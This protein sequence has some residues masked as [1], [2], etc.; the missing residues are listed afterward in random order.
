[1]GHLPDNQIV[2]K[3]FRNFLVSVLNLVRMARQASR[4][5][6]V[7][8]LH[9][10]HAPPFHL[11]SLDGSVWCARH[12]MVTWFITRGSHAESSVCAR[13]PGARAQGRSHRSRCPLP[14]GV[15]P[16]QRQR[17]A[18]TYHY[19]HTRPERITAANT[20]YS[21]VSPVFGFTTAFDPTATCQWVCSVPRN[22]HRF[23]QIFKQYFT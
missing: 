11:G 2:G 15:P 9:K 8:A 23:C 18:R 12:R 21:L 5:V 22:F 14:S 16:D 3:S 13:L 6:G 7:A 20:S 19:K 4:R 10:A 17:T 1:M